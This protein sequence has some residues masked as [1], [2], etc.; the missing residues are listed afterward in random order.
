MKK[1][2]AI[3]SALVVMSSSTVILNVH[4]DTGMTYEEGKA[5]LEQWEEQ[6]KANGNQVY[7]Q[8][9]DGI[10]YAYNMN[11]GFYTDD[12]ENPGIYRRTSLLK[13]LSAA[14]PEGK[15]A[16]HI[17]VFNS[18]D[19]VAWFQQHGIEVEPF[20]EYPGMLYTFLT[21]EQLEQFPCDPDVG[22]RLGLAPD[23][24]TLPQ[25][26]DPIL[27]DANNDGVIDIMDVIFLNKY[28]LGSGPMDSIQKKCAD[29]NQDGVLE[30]DD[31]LQILRYVVGEI[32]HFNTTKKI[33]DP[34]KT[35]RWGNYDSFAEEYKTRYG[36]MPLTL[37]ETE[38]YV[39]NVD[40]ITLEQNRYKY[41]LVALSPNLNVICPDENCKFTL[42][43]EF[44]GDYSDYSSFIREYQKMSK[45]IESVSETSSFILMDDDTLVLCGKIKDKEQVYILDTGTGD[46]EKGREQLLRLAEK[47]GIL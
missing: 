19:H 18:K 46:T 42:T 12:Q 44:Q 27:G 13:V 34:P 33:Q 21:S 5:L 40:F 37:S 22:Y 45:N 8:G 16:V 7:Y 29:C 6:W 43:V 32:D 23:R 36:N 47:V 26:P 4:A 39:F 1:I 41:H 31:A 10:Y 35:D 3:I 24:S 14:Y 17:E 38:D 28:I 30:P 20:G 9:N 11:D 15:F 2:L 25:K